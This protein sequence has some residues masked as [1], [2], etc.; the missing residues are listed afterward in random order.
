MISLTFPGPAVARVRVA[1]ARLQLVRSTFER[2]ANILLCEFS[3]FAAWADMASEIRLH[4]CRFAV[5]QA[6]EGLPMMAVVNGTPLP[7]VPG[8]RFWLTNNVAIPSGFEW[9]PAV[10]EATLRAAVATAFDACPDSAIILWNVD[11]V[12]DAANASGDR[13]ELV[14]Q[15]DFI[16]ATRTNVRATLEAVLK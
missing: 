7:P 1:K 16:T 11:S 13:L 9:T 6:Y 15:T 4:A 2:P 12:S 10:D 3:A 5:T 8:R 14:A